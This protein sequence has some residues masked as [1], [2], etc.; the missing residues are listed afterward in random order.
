MGSSTTPSGRAV[1]NIL[2]SVPDKQQV[3]VSTS[4]K[5]SVWDK[6]ALSALQ[7]IKKISKDYCFRTTQ[8]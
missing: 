1:V 8:N 3:G 6:Q 4:Y 2:V 7:Y 5:L